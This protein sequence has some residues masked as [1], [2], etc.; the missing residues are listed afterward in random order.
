M[1]VILR[2]IVEEDYKQI[3]IWRND[4][5]IMKG[6]Y[7][8][9]KGH[10]ITWEEHLEWIQSRN[11]DFKVY[12]IN[13]DDTPLKKVGVVTIGQLDHWE[14][15]T[16]IYIG[17]K[18]LWGMGIAKEALCQII[19][20]LRSMGYKYTRATIMDDN[21][22]SIGLYEGLGFKKVGNARPGESHYRME[23]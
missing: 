22:R 14:P 12:I 18:S 5:L 6:F 1:K 4:P 2:P 8:Q 15:E 23:L 3:L 9:S 20:M 19:N 10:I 11:K 21:E 13:T 16:G 7:S 17:E